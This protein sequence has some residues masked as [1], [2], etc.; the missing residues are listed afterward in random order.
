MQ[1]AG[2]HWPTG[3]P[4]RQISPVLQSASRMHPD[5]QTQA[6]PGTPVMVAKLQY[7][8]G[9]A[10]QSESETHDPSHAPPPSHSS[11]RLSVHLVARGTL[12][13]QSRFAGRCTAPP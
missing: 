6:G 11:V 12:D 3:S 5:L 8:F 10:E 9:D 13:G 1:I 4:Q 2:M 7:P